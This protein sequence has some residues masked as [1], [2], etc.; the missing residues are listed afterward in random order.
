MGIGG[1]VLSGIVQSFPVRRGGGNRSAAHGS[2]NSV[3]YCRYSGAEHGLVCGIGIAE[4][5]VDS[6]G[7]EKYFNPI[8]TALLCT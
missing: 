5:W 6:V 7:A 2:S 3:P 8:I 4:N 1:K